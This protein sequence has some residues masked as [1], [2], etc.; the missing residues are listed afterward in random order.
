MS[1]QDLLRA[2]NGKLNELSFTPTPTIYWGNEKK[3]RS[4]SAPF[5]QPFYRTDG[6]EVLSTSPVHSK[7]NITYDVHC[8]V[9]HTDGPDELSRLTDAV[10]ALFF[11]TDGT[12][13]V[14]NTAGGRRIQINVKP[15]LQPLTA[16]GGF[17]GAQ[18]LVRCFALV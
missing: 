9:E 8:W 3:E 5:L 6:N 10:S 17:T 12:L 13:G 18:V 14:I 7:L 16:R 15:D 2:L 1:D 4:L 11:P